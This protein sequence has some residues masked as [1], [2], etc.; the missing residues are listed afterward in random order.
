MTSEV[1]SPLQ[2][3]LPIIT[4]Q[5]MRAIKAPPYGSLKA[6]YSRTGKHPRHCCGSMESV[7]LSVL[8]LFA[9]ANGSPF[10][11]R[12]R[13]KCP[14]ACRFICSF[15]PIAL[16][17]HQLID[18]PGYRIRLE[19]RIGSRCLLFLRF[20]GRQKARCPRLTFFSYHPT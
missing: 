5:A 4:P 11:S 12:I 14:Q 18:H 13:E 17:I 15:C 3:H 9:F 1:G 10:H 2:I 8:Y 7:R 6:P 19:R 20:Q 16:T